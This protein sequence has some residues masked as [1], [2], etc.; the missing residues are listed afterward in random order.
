MAWSLQEINKNKT[1]INCLAGARKWKSMVIQIFGL[2]INLLFVFLWC[3]FGIFVVAAA[4][5]MQT[6]AIYGFDMCTYMEIP[7]E[8]KMC[9]LSEVGHEQSVGGSQESV[10]KWCFHFCL[11]FITFQLSKCLQYFPFWVKR[12]VVSIYLFC[13]FN[14]IFELDC[15]NCDNV[16]IQIFWVNTNTRNMEFIAINNRIKWKL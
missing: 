15:E 12:V 7:I 13:A 8:Q 1:N 3:P 5:N 2:F 4:F 11:L 10:P 14:H 6:F 9:A 16:Y